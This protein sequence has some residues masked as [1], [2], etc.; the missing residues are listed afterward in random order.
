ME[1]YP[2]ASTW[3]QYSVTYITDIPRPPQIEMSHSADYIAAF[4]SNITLL[5]SQNIAYI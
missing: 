3:P 5:Q 1:A 4:T 2:R